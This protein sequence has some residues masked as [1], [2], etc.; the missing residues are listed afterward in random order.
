LLQLPGNLFSIH[1]KVVPQTFRFNRAFAYWMRSLKLV[2]FNYIQALSQRLILRLKLSSMITNQ[3]ARFSDTVENYIKYR[4]SYPDGFVELLKKEISLNS[5]SVVADLGS[6]TGLSAEPFLKLGCTVFGVEPNAEMRAA[7]A[8]LLS[9]YPN[10]VSLTGSAESTG[11]ADSSIDVAIVA[12]A[13]HWFD[14]DKSR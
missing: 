12:Q 14:V 11:P 7:G 4:P 8:R 2:I 9:G 3:T 10:F 13:F 5:E 1:K 6:G